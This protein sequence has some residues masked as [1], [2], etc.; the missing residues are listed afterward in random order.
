MYRPISNK[1]CQS[2]QKWRHLHIVDFSACI[3][4]TVLCVF[5]LKNGQRLPNIGLERPLSV[6]LQRK[7]SRSLL[8]SNTAYPNKQTI[9]NIWGRMGGT[10][11]T[12]VLYQKTPWWQRSTLCDCPSARPSP[13]PVWRSY[14]KTKHS[15][16]W[17]KRGCAIPKSPPNA[18]EKHS[19]LSPPN[20]ENKTGAAELSAYCGPSLWG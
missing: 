14:F 4:V 8:I 6:G 9:L 18:P 1:K 13:H 12:D 2:E 15:V 20:L 19:F 7:T 3:L 10:V 11:S 16:S 5:T 17:G